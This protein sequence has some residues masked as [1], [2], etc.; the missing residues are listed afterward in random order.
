MQGKLNIKHYFV[1][2][3]ALF[4]VLLQPLHSLQHVYNDLVAHDASSHEHVD[5]EKTDHHDHHKTVKCTVCEFTFQ[6]YLLTEITF[7]PF[8][9]VSNVSDQILTSE[10]AYYFQPNFHNYLRGPP[11]LFLV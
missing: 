7:V 1:L 2:V 8:H 9:L 11:A 5:F 10:I 6:P 3:T 4:L